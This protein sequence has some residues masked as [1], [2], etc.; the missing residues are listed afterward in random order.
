MIEIKVKPHGNSK[1]VTPFICTSESAQQ[2]IQEVAMKEKPKSA[3]FTLTKEAGGEVEVTTPSVL[4][5]NRQQI[6]NI[7]RSHIVHDKNVLYSVML[8]CKLTQGSNE[9]FV[10]D[11]KAAPS[12]QC[13]LYFDWQLSEMERFLTNNSEFGVLTV[14]T[15]FCLGE[16]YITLITY[17]HLMLQDVNTGKHPT[18]IGPA[19]IHQETNFSSFN[20]FGATL[21]SNCKNLQNILC[22][23]T[24]GDRSLVEA[25]GHNFPHALQLRCFIH[26]KKMCRRSCVH[27]DSL[28]L[29]LM[30]W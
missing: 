21:I 25:F 7:R 3:V 16:F 15:T 1:S 9:A 14:D 10:R 8:E 20:Y 27:L 12:P 26:K 24:D 19:L 11:L 28:V 5:R 29:Y 2:R 17:P 6:S 13:V 4:P 18:M 23:G 30:R 22:F